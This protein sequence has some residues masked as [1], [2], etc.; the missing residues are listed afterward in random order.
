MKKQYLVGIIVVVVSLIA[1]GYAAKNNNIAKKEA[2]S[3]TAGT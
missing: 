2:P 3:A 1:I